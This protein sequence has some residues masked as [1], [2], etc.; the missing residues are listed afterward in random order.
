MRDAFGSELYDIATSNPNMIVVVPC[1]P[2]ESCKATRAAF[3]DP[4][5]VYVRSKKMASRTYIK[6]EYDFRVGQAVQMRD[7]NDATLIATGA[8]I[9]YGSPNEDVEMLL[10]IGEFLANMLI[11]PLPQSLEY[12]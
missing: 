9:R 5:P 2:L 1:D 12:L 8:V 7:G 11:K 4:G 6:D 3:E 10:D